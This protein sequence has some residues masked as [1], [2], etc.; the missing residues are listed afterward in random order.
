VAGDQPERALG[1][2]PA[3]AAFELDDGRIVLAGADGEVRVHDAATGALL[4]T[5]PCHDGAIVASALHPSRHWLATGGAGRRYELVDLDQGKL[6][7]ANVDWPAGA[8]GDRERVLALAFAPNGDELFL[9]GENLRLRAVELREGFPWREK[10]K[11]VTPGRL[12]PS[13]DGR[14]LFVGGWWS[15]KL[16]RH[17]V[18]DLDLQVAYPARHSNLLVALE[19][20]PGGRL[21]LSASKDG[22]VSV[23]DADRDQLLS[24]IH[25][26]DGTLVTAA[27]HPDGNS[28]LTADADGVV[29]VWPIDPLALALRVRPARL[30]DMGR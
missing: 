22:L 17:G 18:R 27:F 7:H 6:L 24:V 23:F 9:S 30:P 26:S 4:H 16:Y 14:T 2:T 29:R 28:I 8:L 11:A 1:T 5:V 3:T 21:A 15:G 13:P 20:Q 12:L 19:R 25:A 10:S